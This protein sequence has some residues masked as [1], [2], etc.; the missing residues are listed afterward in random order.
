[1]LDLLQ[2]SLLPHQ[3]AEAIERFAFYER[4]QDAFAIVVTGERQPFGNFILAQGRHRRH[5]A[6]MT[7]ELSRPPP[8]LRPRGSNHVGMR[9]FNERVVLQAIRQNGSLP[10]A[11][12]ARLT[13]LTARPS[14]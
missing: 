11:E 4:V 5:S 13:G 10:K 8:L 6:S 7:A 14:A 12:L 1:V 2:P 9:Q 3:R